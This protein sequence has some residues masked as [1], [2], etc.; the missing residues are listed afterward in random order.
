MDKTVSKVTSILM[1]LGLAAAIYF[2]DGPAEFGNPTP[3]NRAATGIAGLMIVAL[4][5]FAM[6]LTRLRG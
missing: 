3:D 2:G 6:R 4:G 5:I 1:M